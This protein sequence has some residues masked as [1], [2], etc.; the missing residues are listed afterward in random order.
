MP[1]MQT[2]QYIWILRALHYVWHA[3]DKRFGLKRNIIILIFNMPL[4]DAIYTLRDLSRA[5]GRLFALLKIGMVM[6][7]L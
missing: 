7:L 2:V 1:W 4:F 3:D 5:G 6:L